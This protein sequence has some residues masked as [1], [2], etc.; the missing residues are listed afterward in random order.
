MNA[1]LRC[2]QFSGC[3]IDCIPN[4]KFP[5]EATVLFVHCEDGEWVT[6]GVEWDHVPSCERKLLSV[7]HS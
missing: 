3:R 1:A 6:E 7:K 4:Y 5:N 2:S